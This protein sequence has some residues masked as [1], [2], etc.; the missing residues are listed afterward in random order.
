MLASTFDSDE[1]SSYHKDA[2]TRLIVNPSER[3]SVSTIVSVR[4][5]M[6][7]NISLNVNSNLGLSTFMNISRYKDDFEIESE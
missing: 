1:R 5:S 3:K 7:V 2:S 6:N 4:M